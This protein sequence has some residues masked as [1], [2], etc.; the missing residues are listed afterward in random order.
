VPPRE[1]ASGPL[2]RAARIV[3]AVAVARNGLTQQQIA[4]VVG[5]P[6]STTFRLV[7]SLI[8]VGYLAFEADRKV[9]HL[10]RR[11]IR[12]FHM[13]MAAERIQ[14]LVEPVLHDVVHQF[15]QI[16]YLTQLRND[17]VRLVAFSMPHNA[18][19]TLIYPGETSLIHAQA[20]GKATFA[21]QDPELIERHLAR[22]LAKLQPNTKTDPRE[23]RRE[24]AEVRRKGY[25]I[26]DSE[27]EQGVFAVSCP[28]N[29]P[30]T[31]VIFAIALAGFKSQLFERHKLVD[32]VSALQAAAQS[33]ARILPHADLSSSD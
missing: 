28:V 31:G 5:L 20:A 1:G 18:N 19:R 10:G 2:S 7:R 17:E 27:F 8:A 29:D 13:R 14:A 6:P 16:C 24:L 30:K 22:P 25:A 15:N 32:Y 33:L 23:I 12:L 26:T 9:Y 4:D 11:I 3:D 21:F